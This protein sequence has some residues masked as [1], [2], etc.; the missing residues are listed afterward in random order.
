LAAA[1]ERLDG[2]APQARDLDER[3]IAAAG[4]LRE[5]ERARARLAEIGPA[6]EAKRRRADL[7]AEMSGLIGS[8]DGSRFRVF[9]QGLTLDALV[10]HANAHLRELQPR[11]RLARVPGQ[12]LEIQ[13][14]DRD[15][16]DEVRSVAS[17]SGGET[18]LASLALA[19]GLSALAAHDVRV[20]SLF[21]D[22]GFGSL[23]PDTLELALAVLDELQA[24]GRQI[25]VISH[26]PG[27]A[28][29]I[30]VRVQVVPQGAG[31]AEVRI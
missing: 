8:H 13:V 20:D 31:R 18:F 3:R 29:R 5:D 9:A 1:R 25:G 14:V 17:L 19:L 15:M 27:I 4:R 23:D 16:G 21:I 7:W 12:D 10:M 11:Y 28:E 26:I 24:R 6:L 22:E 2:L 30:G